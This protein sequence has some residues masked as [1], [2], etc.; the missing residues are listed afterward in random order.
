MVTKANKVKVC[1][2]CGKCC[3]Y[4]DPRSKKWKP[5]KYLTMIKPGVSFCTIYDHHL[6]MTIDLGVVCRSE[7]VYNIPGCPYNSEIKMPHPLWIA[8][9]VLL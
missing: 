1:N 8:Q 3:Y 6:G 7:P 4:L 5:C 2:R 9:K